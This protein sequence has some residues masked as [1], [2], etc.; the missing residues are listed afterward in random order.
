MIIQKYKKVLAYIFA[1]MICVAYTNSN[2]QPNA[3]W[4]DL[5]NGEDLSN[6]KVKFTGQP[7]GVNYRNTFRVEDNLLTVSYEDWVDSMA[8]LDTYSSRINSLI[9]Y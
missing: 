2:G 1:A 7:L 8:N 3:G 5:F 6:W 4:I 9:M